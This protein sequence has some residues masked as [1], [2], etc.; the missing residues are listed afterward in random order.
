[1]GLTTLMARHE[2]KRARCEA[3]GQ[4]LCAGC[5][6]RCPQCGAMHIKS[7]IKNPDDPVAWVD[8]IPVETASGETIHNA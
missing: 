5:V 4:Q 2:L 3:C 6:K 1:M 7:I 8:G